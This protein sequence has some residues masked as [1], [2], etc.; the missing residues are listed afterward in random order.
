M[1]QQWVDI[2][3]NLTNKRYNK[4]RDSVI[5][6]AIEQGVDKLIITGTSVAESVTASEMAANNPKHLF[7]TAGCHPH[8]AKSLD[9]D[10]LAT[11]KALLGQKHVV[12]VGDRVSLRAWPCRSCGDHRRLRA[13]V[14][15][16][17]ADQECHGA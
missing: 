13:F 14:W 4:D 1:G 12:A 16:R 3:I 6:A 17:A 10:G 9:A 7:A 11:I 15:K 5:T 2:G 8:D